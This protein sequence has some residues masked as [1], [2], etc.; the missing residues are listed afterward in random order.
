MFDTGSQP[1]CGC[2]SHGV[3]ITMYPTTFPPRSA[4]WRPLEVSSNRG[5]P[6]TRWLGWFGVSPETS[7]EIESK[8][9][10]TDLAES[11]LGH[12]FWRVFCFF[13]SQLHGWRS[14]Q[15]L[16]SDVLEMSLWS[17]VLLQWFLARARP[18]KVGRGSDCHW[19]THDAISEKHIYICT[20]Y[21]CI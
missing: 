15:L 4:G 7:K 1:L 3:Y 10:L 13:L 16:A 18:G 14:T 19:A 8:S 11:L 6:Q 20:L 2:L 17:Q 5:S 12:S 9:W 21:R